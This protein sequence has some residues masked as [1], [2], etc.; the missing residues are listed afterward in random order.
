MADSAFGAASGKKN[1]MAGDSGIT[2]DHD[3]IRRWAE[4]R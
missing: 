2:T 3:E 4:E 1:R